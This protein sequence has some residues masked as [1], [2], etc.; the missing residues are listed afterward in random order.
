VEV[1]GELRQG[2]TGEKIN[3]GAGEYDVEGEEGA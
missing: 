2:E 3:D 1:G